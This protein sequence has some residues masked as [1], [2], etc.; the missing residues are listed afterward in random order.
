MKKKSGMRYRVPKTLKAAAKKPK[1][2]RNLQ[3][4]QDLAAAQDLA[5]S[6]CNLLAYHGCSPRV[7]ALALTIAH[8][9]V[10]RDSVMEWE[11]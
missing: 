10:C 2:R 7:A 3:A 1:N 11:R 5:Q 4:L 8:G 9:V 6:I